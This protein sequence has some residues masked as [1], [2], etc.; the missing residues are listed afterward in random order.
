MAVPQPQMQAVL[1]RLAALRTGLPSRYELPFTEA[2][3]QLLREREPWLAD[4]PRCTSND[5]EVETGRRTFG[6]RVVRPVTT[7]PQRLLVYLH[8]GGWCVGFAADA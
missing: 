2:R 3:V 7:S 8:G 1:E 5:R 6:M 4:G